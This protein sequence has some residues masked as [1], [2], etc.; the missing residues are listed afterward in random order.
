MKLDYTATLADGTVLKLEQLNGDTCGPEC[1][2][3][4]HANCAEAPDC[5]VCDNWGFP[6]FSG[7][8]IEQPRKDAAQ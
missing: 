6:M 2:Y 5:E 4:I 7:M 1:Y 3:R 8:W